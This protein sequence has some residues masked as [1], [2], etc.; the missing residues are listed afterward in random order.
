[1]RPCIEKL[2]AVLVLILCVFTA[3]PAQTYA[4][5]PVKTTNA[6]DNFYGNWSGPIRSYLGVAPDGG[7]E[8]VEWT[9]ESGLVAETYSQDFVIQS[10]VTIDP[11][12]YTPTGAETV[13]WGG[14]YADAASRYVVTGQDNHEESDEKAVVRVTKYDKD[15]KYLDHCE[16]SAINTYVP[17]AFGSLRMME[18]DGVLWIRTCHEMYALDDGLHHQS[19]MT[20][21]VDTATMEP[22]KGYTSPGYVSHSFNQFILSAN[23]TVYTIDHG[24]AYSRSVALQQIAP[25]DNHEVTVL[26]IEGEIGDNYTGVTVGGFTANEAGTSFLVAGTTVDQDRQFATGNSARGAQN[27]FLSL[28]RNPTGLEQATVETKMLTDYAFDSEVTATTPHLVKINN[29]RYLVLWGEGRANVFESDGFFYVFVDG[30][31]D[32]LGSVKKAA[33]EL[34][35]C[36]PIV[37]GNKVVWYYT[38]TN[39]GEGFEP[40]APQ[41]VSV[42]AE[43]GAVSRVDA[44]LYTVSFDPQNGEP[45]S[46]QTVRGG[47]V[48]AQ[49]ANPVRAGY[50]FT[51]WYDENNDPYDFSLSASRDI[52]LHACWDPLFTDVDASTPHAE[53]IWWLS[54]SGV[55]TGW[56]NEDGS[57]SHFSGMSTVVRQ[58]MAAFLHRLARYA[59]LTLDTPLSLSFTDVTNAT[60]HADDIRWLAATGISYGWKN[61]QDSGYHFSGMSGVTR[62]DMA[63]FLYRLAG[64]P[65]YEPSAEDR[66]KFSDVTNAT[67]HA[68]EIWWLASTGVSTGWDDGN[69]TAHFSGMSTVVRQDMAAFLHRLYENVLSR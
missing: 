23:S 11:A 55:S 10:S 45:A 66:A 39:L 61:E 21:R 50:T 69:G 52:A 54:E 67:P 34:S 58:D 12:T 31:G 57:G 9:D 30:D 36:A 1:M 51:G 37:V 22:V 42:D 56:E 35:D 33:G 19:N 46:S 17:F 29:D 64:E 44:S 65:A 53:D 18:A 63:A 4:L 68:K 15:W 62:Q 43:T 47:R 20:L 38:T 6:W 14:Y 27:V 8:R 60:P 28:V 49:P 2:C 24:D 25:L 59:G 26:P 41:F 16:F 32:T 3:A 48:F 5:S 13:L 7:Y 40:S